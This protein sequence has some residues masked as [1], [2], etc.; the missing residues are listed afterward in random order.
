MIEFYLIKRKLIVS[1]CLRYV[2]NTD[3]VYFLEVCN[4]YKVEI[5]RVHYFFNGLVNDISDFVVAQIFIISTCLS[6][7]LPINFLGD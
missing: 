4:R 6:K 2:D 1:T 7:V 5:F 3:F